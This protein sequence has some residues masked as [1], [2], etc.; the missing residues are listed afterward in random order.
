MEDS[1]EWFLDRKDKHRTIIRE[2]TGMKKA[3][4][5]MRKNRLSLIGATSSF[6]FCVEELLSL[7][8]KEKQMVN[9]G[10]EQTREALKKSSHFHTSMVE[11]HSYQGEADKLVIWFCEDQIKLV[12]RANEALQMRRRRLRQLWNMKI[13]KVVEEDSDK[14]VTLA[15]EEFEALSLTLRTELEHLDRMVSEDLRRTMTDHRVRSLVA[16]ANVEKQN[17]YLK[18]TN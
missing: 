6:R 3:A 12:R 16:L 10:E 11:L 13:K 8:S 5:K 18:Y 2:M 1:D 15:E 17:L 4:Q 7:E 14:E 9:S